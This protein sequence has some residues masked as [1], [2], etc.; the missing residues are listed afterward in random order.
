MDELVQ[1]VLNSRLQDMFDKDY[2]LDQPGTAFLWVC[3]M[4]INGKTCYG[5]YRRIT[6]KCLEGRDYIVENH[7]GGVCVKILDSIFNPK[8][9]G[10]KGWSRPLEPQRCVW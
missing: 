9:S 10:V 4:D 1:D 5:S 8:F 3:L 7:D 6:Q 2:G